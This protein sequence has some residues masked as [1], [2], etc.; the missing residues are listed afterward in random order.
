VPAR[1]GRARYAA[2]LEDAQR[3]LGMVR[4]R[5]GEWGLDSKRIGVLGFSAGGHLAAAL[6]NNFET[7]TY[8]PADD[9][10]RTSCRPDFTILIYP[11]YLV[12]MGDQSGKLASE[13]NVTAQ[14]PTAFVV[15]TED[16]PVRME[17]SLF[18]YLALK[19]AKI[20]AEMHLFSKGGHGYGLRA[21]GAPVAIWPQYAE[22]WLKFSG[23]IPK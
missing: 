18:Y 23:V 17:N 19:N 11:A 5:A 20:P 9:A 2:P 6:S 12:T 10:D 22:R 4:S 15:Q 7:R 14:T 8:P 3:A 13:I 1:A 16:D 21:T